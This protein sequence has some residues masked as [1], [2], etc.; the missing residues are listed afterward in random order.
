MDERRADRGLPYLAD[1]A[2][3][4]HRTTA[5]RVGEY[6]PKL[7]TQRLRQT[8]CC[9]RSTMAAHTIVLVHGILGFGSIPRV[10]LVAEYFNGVA[11]HLRKQGHTVV[12]PTVDPIGSVAECGEQLATAI[13]A[14]PL[15]DGQKL[16]VIGHSMGGLDAR[17]A[18]SNIGRDGISQQVSARVQTLVTI[19]TPHRGSPVA[20]AI[21]AGADDL[22]RSIPPFLVD[23]L[24]DNA[25][26]L[27]DLTTPVATQV[28]QSTPDVPGV[29]Y[30]EV[31]GDASKGGEELLFFQ[32]AAAIGGIHGVNDGLV[33]ESSALRPGHEHLE[34]WPT[35][36]GGEIGWSRASPFPINL[37]TLALIELGVLPAPPHLAW[38]DAIVDLFDDPVATT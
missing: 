28:D 18:L 37:A 17:H 19:G 6:R 26:A 8:A 23:A 16:H 3:P 35:D 25:A 30:I 12:A 5:R 2:L 13:L 22:L 38:Y 27:N 14:E 24:R 34:D 11:L 20:D 9:R 31:A 1:A 7:K 36:H 29:R 33:T 21:A 4:F 15:A 10:P 32:L